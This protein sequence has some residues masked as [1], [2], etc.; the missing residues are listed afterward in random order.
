MAEREAAG[1]S[2]AGGPRGPRVGE[3]GA[4]AVHLVELGTTPAPRRG[5]SE[6]EAHIGKLG[7]AA[8]QQVEASAA[9]PTTRSGSRQQPDRKRR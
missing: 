8:V 4:I 6:V 2:G 3:R 9:T 7:G 1:V 5:P